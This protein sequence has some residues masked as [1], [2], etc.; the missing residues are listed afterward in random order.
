MNKLHN[1]RV[2]EKSPPKAL[3]SRSRTAWL[4]WFVPIAAA[5]LCVWFIYRDFVATGPLITIYFQNVEGLE[6]GNTQIQYRGAQIGEV[7]SITLADGGGRVKVTARLTASAKNLARSGSL[8]WI[9]R[10]EVKVGAISG[11]QTIVSGEYVTLQPGSGSP[12]N[13]FLA[14]EK[15][16]PDEE[17]NALVLTIRSRGLDSLQ[18]RSPI[19]YRGIQV[20]EVLDYQLADDAHSV[21]VRARVRSEYAPLVR[22][23]SQFWN[24]GGISVHIGLFKGAEISAQSAQTLLSGGIEFATPPEP[25]PPAGNGAIFELN[26]KPK[27][28]WKNWSPTIPLSLPSQ[29]PEQ[30]LPSRPRVKNSTL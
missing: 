13:A 10:P 28:E 19:F 2:A 3:V 24:A 26:E 25:A 18:D 4:F 6:E 16:P 1:G 21:L 14:V 20:G 5:S 8:F 11:L 27:E 29:A 9:V 30:N 22:L 7:K 23:N 17:Q 12:T 15:A